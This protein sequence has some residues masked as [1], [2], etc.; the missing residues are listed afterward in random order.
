M[1]FKALPNFSTCMVLINS[2]AH[3]HE[4]E[5]KTKQKK[6]VRLLSRGVGC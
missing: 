5:N 4:G 3:I 1:R 2:I 6:N